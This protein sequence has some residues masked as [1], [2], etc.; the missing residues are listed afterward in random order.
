MIDDVLQRLYDDELRYIRKSADQFAKDLPDIAP[1]LRLNARGSDDPY[2]ER[3]IEAF[4]FLAARVRL[5]IEDDFSLVARSLMDVIAPH[6]LRPIPSMSVVRFAFPEGRALPDGCKV[7]RGTMLESEELLDDVCCR[8]RTCSDT[9][10]HPIEVV[11]LE[12]RSA[13]EVPTGSV[14]M[15][16]PSAVVMKLKS[17]AHGLPFGKMPLDPIHLY[18][19]GPP[20]DANLLVE[21]LCARTG[22]AKIVGDRVIPVP[23][24][25]IEIS[26]FDE[27]DAMLPRTGPGLGGFRVLTEFFAMPE[28]LRFVSVRGLTPEVLET[29]GNE[30]TLVIELDARHD[31]LARFISPGMLVPGCTPIVNLFERPLDPF[32]LEPGSTSTRLGDE[33]GERESTGIYTIDRVELK[34][35]GSG[36]FESLPRIYAAGAVSGGGS[37]LRWHAERGS[38]GSPGRSSDLVHLTIVDARVDSR[39]RELPQGTVKVTATC[40][41][42]DLPKRLSGGVHGSTL[43]FV[44]GGNEFSP[45]SLLVQPTAIRYPRNGD[46]LEWR[47][48]S[49]FALG[50]LSLL[51]GEKGAEELR[52]LLEIY[53]F[54]MD[55]VW[56]NRIKRGITS[57]H[58][59]HGVARVGRLDRSAI[60]RG[61]DTTIRFDGTRFADGSLYL[62][63][64][65][66]DR[67]LASA[68][69]LNSFSRLHVRTSESDS[70]RPFAS[71]PPRAGTM[72]LL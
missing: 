29:V 23:G 59:E 8:F 16:C 62:F 45:P 33:P 12:I 18:V 60:I 34:R 14:R 35:P 13:S 52:N 50:R 38:V 21:V 72:D 55:D 64:A 17:K 32:V 22:D 25:Q 47:L 26:G 20:N 7:P 48:I 28:R 31:D 58:R 66:L 4:A 1:A 54:C 46:G 30:L 19:D 49:H 69:S 40:T 9:V 67:L 10:V 61:I 57:I 5:R 44:D 41:N 2:V 3:L 37:D 27:D 65:V 68:V 42:R 39:S 70:E 51:G 15:D 24:L 53:A 71:W 36:E 56:R 11:S 63:A 6:Y 43:R